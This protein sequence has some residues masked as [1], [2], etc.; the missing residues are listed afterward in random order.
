[1]RPGCE[2]AEEALVEPSR[3]NEER[4]QAL[5]QAL[6]REVNERRRLESASDGV[7]EFTCECSDVKC[8]ELV[9]LTVDEYEFIR[10]VPNRLVVRI[11]HIRPNSERV[12]MEEPGRFQVLEKFGP[13]EDVVSHLDPRRRVWPDPRD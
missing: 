3:K 9:S 2:G 6:R 8:Q 10:Q 12:I 4:Q 5:Y 7:L 13:G 11:G 1:M